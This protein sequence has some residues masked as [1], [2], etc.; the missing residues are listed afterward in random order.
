MSPFMQKTHHELARRELLA[1]DAAGDHEI[2]CE[3]GEL[4]ITVEGPQ[5]VILGPGESYSAGKDAVVVVSALRD[6]TLT[7]AHPAGCSPACAPHKAGAEWKLA[8]LL[9][10][11]VA[12]LAASRAPCIG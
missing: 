11:R 6:S 3:S 2:T 8:G 5:D 1:I 12:P 10:W 4:W 7:L 9:R